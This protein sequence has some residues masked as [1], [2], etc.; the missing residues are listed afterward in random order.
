MLIFQRIP[1]QKLHWALIY[2]FVYQLINFNFF[3]FELVSFLHNPSKKEKF[4]IVVK[5]IQPSLAKNIK[6]ILLY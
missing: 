1:Q 5:R 3:Y 4:I 2:Q 6:D